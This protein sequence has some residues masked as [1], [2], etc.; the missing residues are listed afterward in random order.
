M[1]RIKEFT[2]GRAFTIPDGNFGSD[3]PSFSV[4][5]ELAEGD[6]FEDEVA[7]AMT[8]VNEILLLIPESGSSQD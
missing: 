8:T 2:L 5:V 4:T 6:S 7:K 1:A 3:K